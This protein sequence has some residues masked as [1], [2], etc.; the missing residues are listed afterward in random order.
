MAV[1]PHYKGTENPFGN[2]WDVEDFNP[3]RLSPSDVEEAPLNTRGPPRGLSLPGRSGTPRNKASTGV[4]IL[5]MQTFP[6]RAV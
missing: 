5:S 2:N 4:S 6:K 3:Q 1:P